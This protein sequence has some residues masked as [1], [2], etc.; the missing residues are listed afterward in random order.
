[1][2]RY[3]IRRTR[4]SRIGPLAGLS[5]G[6]KISVSA[7]GGT[8]TGGGAFDIIGGLVGNHLGLGA[9]VASYASGAVISGGGND[10]IGGLVGQ[11]GAMIVASYATGAVAG[12]ADNDNVGGLV[13]SKYNRCARRWTGG[14]NQ[15]CHRKSQWLRRRPRRQCRRTCGGAFL[16][17]RL[18]PATPPPVRSMATLALT[19]S[20]RL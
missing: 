8:T 6:T 13:G 20:A 12:D 1:M 9:I 3:A 10:T 11:N 2:R 7:T 17:A 16:K 19:M 18:R 15:L 4:S 14:R 5:V